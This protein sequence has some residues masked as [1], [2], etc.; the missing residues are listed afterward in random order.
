MKLKINGA[1]QRLSQSSRIRGTKR[2][3]KIIILLPTSAVKQNVL[4]K[5]ILKKILEIQTA[6][7]CDIT[8]INHM[9]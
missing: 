6:N 2:T 8:E 5:V 9:D 7:D 1:R 4:K 3:L